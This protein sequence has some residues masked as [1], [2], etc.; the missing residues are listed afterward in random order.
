MS[1]SDLFIIQDDILLWSDGFWCFR[2]ELHPRFLRDDDFQVVECGSDEWD[3]LA[4]A[5]ATNLA[6]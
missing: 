1:E 3:E 5:S 2:E 6:K 4:L